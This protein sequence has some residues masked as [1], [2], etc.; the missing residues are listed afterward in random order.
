MAA[1]LAKAAP[2]FYVVGLLTGLTAAWAGGWNFAAPWLVTSYVIFAIMIALDARFRV[3]WVRRV[4]SAAM[5]CPD[6]ALSAELQA[7]LT[8][9]RGTIT[10]WAGPPAILIVVFLMVYKPFQ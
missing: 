3:P 10:T 6:G 7:A 1:P 5:V 2:T 8:D 9:R 4:I